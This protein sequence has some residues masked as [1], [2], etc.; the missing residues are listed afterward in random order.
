MVQKITV[1]G[2]EIDLD[3]FRLRNFVNR[4]NEIGELE[5]HEEPVALADLSW[6]I[7]STPKAKLFKKAGPEGF[8]IA[9]ATAGSRKRLAAALGVELKD[10]IAEYARRL[11]TPQPVIEIPSAQAP[12]HQV[13]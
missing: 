12:V 6:I 7:E 2:R 10:V 1:E 13:V 11:E 3:K 4:L 9:A 5:I 8:E